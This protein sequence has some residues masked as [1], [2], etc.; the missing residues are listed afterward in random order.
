MSATTDKIRAAANEAV[1]RIKQALSG[2]MQAAQDTIN[3]AMDA[4]KKP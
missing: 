2:A 1:G 4:N 3:R